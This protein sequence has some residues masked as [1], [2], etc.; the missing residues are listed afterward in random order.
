VHAA[1]GLAIIVGM[2]APIDWTFEGTWPHPPRWFE[3]P[4]G[5]LHFVDAGPRQG[6]P[7]VLVHGNP[8][9][10]YLYRTFIPALVAAGHRVI[11]PDHLGFGRSDKPEAASVCGVRAHAD[12][13]EAL[14][15]SLDLRGAT[16]VLHDWGGPIGL[17]WATRHPERVAAL[18][19]LNTFAHRPTARVPLALPLRLFRLPGLGE[20]FVKRLDGIVRGFL[21]GAGVRRPERLTRTVRAAYRAPHATPAS[22]TAIL[23]LA[24]QF[25]AGPAGDVAAFVGDLE[26]RLPALSTRPVF[27][28]W[29]GQDVV[30]GA[31]ALARWSTSFPRA[32]LLRV[33]S[34][35]HFL[36]EDAPELVVP[37]LVD[38]LRRHP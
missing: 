16:L 14:L 4:H 27:I 28:A 17:A 20:L 24:R 34:A 29:A 8:T 36:Q 3:T 11:V 37:A 21:F 23:T 1:R 6:R 22:R 18:A 35:G 25:P 33:P 32:E 2:N 30:F 10:G 12:R 26:A 15:E 9:W 13:F 31:A 38:F 19:I 5:R 7:V